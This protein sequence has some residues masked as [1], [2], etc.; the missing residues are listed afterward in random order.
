MIPQELSSLFWDIDTESFVPQDYP[1]Y[2][3]ERILE[4]G[5]SEAVEWLEEQFSEEQIKEVIRT[6]RRL[7]KKSANFWALVYHIP[8]EEVAALR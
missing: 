4:L 2:T 7:S 5:D 6:H 8:S 1:E 3:M